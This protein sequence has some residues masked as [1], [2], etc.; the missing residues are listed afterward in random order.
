[1][2]IVT[3]SKTI[4]LLLPVTDV[5]V[6]SLPLQRLT[7]IVPVTSLPFVMVNDRVVLV[8]VTVTIPNSFIANKFC[9]CQI[10][11]FAD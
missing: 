9:K 2:R 10:R 1:V 3:A 4:T 8:I 7:K 5:S 11:K 6:T